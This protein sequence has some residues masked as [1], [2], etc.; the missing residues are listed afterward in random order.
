M[1]RILAIILVFMLAGCSAMA[2][3]DVDLSGM[4]AQELQQL[5][6]SAEKALERT[7]QEENLVAESVEI[8]KQYWRDNTYA[9]EWY[10]EIED[11]RGYLEIMN[12]RI[13]YIREEM[14]VEEGIK[15]TAESIFG[16]LHCV[17]EFELM[18]DCYGTDPYYFNAGIDNCV[19]VYRDGRIETVRKSPFDMY[20]S[21]TYS[22]DFSGIIESVHNLGS[23]YDAVYYLL[24]E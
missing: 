12:T 8:I 23:A 2:E 24:E 19:T 7:M 3:T 5:I 14:D 1:K 17:V 9:D 18:S 22:N 20:R 4:S 11:S 10:Q 16:D 15:D 6:Q 13:A 21:R